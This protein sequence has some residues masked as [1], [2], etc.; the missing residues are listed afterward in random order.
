MPHPTVIMVRKAK[1]SETLDQVPSVQATSQ[2]SPRAVL[3]YLDR[4][5]PAAEREFLLK[6][7]SAIQLSEDEVSFEWGDFPE[8]KSLVILGVGLE[9]KKSKRMSALRPDAY[10]IPSVERIQGDLK[11]KREVWEKLKSL[12]IRLK[13]LR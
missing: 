2:K 12:A 11:L 9:I 8:S 4:E 10:E 6:M 1:S 13:E 3:L 5:P 7:M